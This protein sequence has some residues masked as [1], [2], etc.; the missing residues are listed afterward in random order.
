MLSVISL[1]LNTSTI[2][3]Q[4]LYHSEGFVIVTH[5]LSNG[6]PKHLTLDVLDAFIN[7]TK[8]LNTC[9]N[10]GPLLKQMFEQ[11]LFAPQLWIRASAEVNIFNNLY[12]LLNFYFLNNFQYS[13]TLYNL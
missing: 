8:F 7:I 4:Q 9:P 11:I 5:V 6:S 2:A 1:L 3:Q 13:T 12:L 10:G